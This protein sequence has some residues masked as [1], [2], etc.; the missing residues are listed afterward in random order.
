MPVVDRPNIVLC[1]FDS[2]GTLGGGTLD[3]IAD[4][5]T[6]SN[7]RSNSACFS[8]AYTPCPE[9]S[10][11]RASLFTG[12]DPSVHG[13]WTNGVTLPDH[14]QTFAQR[15]AK[16]GYSNYL[17][18]RYQLSGVSRWTT[19]QAR[20]G[21]FGQGE[22]TQMDWAHGPL[23]RSRQNSYLK[24][25]QNLSPEQYSRI[26]TVQ[27]KPDHTTLSQPQQEALSALP[28][29]MSF[30]YWVGQ[31]LEKWIESR[32][33]EQPFLA[34][35]G[36][37]VG[38]MMGTEPHPCTD[39]EGLN[40]VALK[41]A[42]H[43]IS[44]IMECL[45]SSC[46]LDD[47]VVVVAA[48]R[49]NDVSLSAKGTLSENSIRVPLII[50]GA[51]IKPQ[52]VDG[53]VSTMDIAPTLLALANVPG[54]PRMQGESLLGALEG[55]L[56]G[57]ATDTSVPRDWGMSRIR[58]SLPSGERNWQT[59]LY[60]RNMKLIVSHGKQQTE[61]SRMFN[62]DTDPLEQ[63]NLAGSDTHAM[64]LEQLMDQMIDA[65]CALEDRTEPR[66]AEF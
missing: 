41:Q 37:C 33:S 17:A 24:W 18:G 34:I 28:D 30:N 55:A 54:G 47:T 26:F 59:A 32:S 8:R 25:L 48:A 29:H 11:A 27:A 20:P 15:L 35:A 43:A 16:A 61:S 2:L 21:E 23:H 6:L 58:Q 60:T 5:P 57:T 10:P 52:T 65:R 51:G 40:T 44:L 62:L 19:E 3:A 1:L 14:E 7:L 56:D 64:Q 22:F 12:L 4:L 53:L 66:I 36:F 45:Q 50:H 42:D 46:R 31:S 63:N 49:G 13:L 9:S 39:L 38:D